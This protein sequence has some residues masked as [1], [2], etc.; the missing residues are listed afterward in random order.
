MHSTASY[1]PHSNGYPSFL[2]YVRNHHYINDSILTNT[3]STSP[4]SAHLLSYSGYNT[5]LDLSSH[6]NNTKQ[7]Q[8]DDE[9]E[10][11]PLSS[12][13]DDTRNSSLVP[14]KRRS[15]LVP[16]EEKDISYYEKRTR[17]NDSAK[18][19]RDSRRTKEQ[20]IQDR[21]MF[22]EHENARLSL[23]NQTIRYKLSQL[24]VLYNGEAK[25][26]Q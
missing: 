11:Q 5:G 15:R 12:S 18:R 16:I 10:N 20:H 3:S 2:S 19:S 25:P 14:I 7:L 9:N 26:L 6:S 1:M 23:E 13:L 17:N 22:F 24:H 4:N 8:S 21:V